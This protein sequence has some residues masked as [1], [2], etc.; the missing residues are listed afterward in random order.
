MIKEYINA[1]DIFI[2]GVM[3][4]K[5]AD[6]FPDTIIDRKLGEA[7]SHPL[8]EQAKAGNVEAA[9]QLAKDLVTDD[10]VEKLRQI[11]GLQR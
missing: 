9:Y 1:D 6:D 2:G 3:R 10:A 8:Y 4:S 5:W 7:T 11:I